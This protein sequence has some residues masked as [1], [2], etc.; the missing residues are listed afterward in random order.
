MLRGLVGDEGGLSLVE[1]R[2]GG[3]VGDIGAASSADG[4]TD[5]GI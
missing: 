4:S 1:Q 5:G 3:V 2:G